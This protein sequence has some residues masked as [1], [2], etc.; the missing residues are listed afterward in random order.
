MDG[1]VKAILALGSMYE[2]GQGRLPQNPE[3][4]FQ[5]FNYAANRIHQEAQ[6]KVAIYC[7]SSTGTDRLEDRA[8]NY[9]RL[10]ANSGHLEALLKASAYYIQGKGVSWNLR[11][12][13]EILT[14][15]ARNGDEGARRKLR[16]A[17]LQMLL[18]QEWSHS[19]RTSYC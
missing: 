12:A 16:L 2:L 17:Q 8:A 7:E 13:I 18:R 19:A 14:P 15:A 10:A 6:W 4:A 5:H 9:F 3:A 1:T 11:T